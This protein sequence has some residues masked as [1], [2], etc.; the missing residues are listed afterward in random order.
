[1]KTD[2]I[3][4]LVIGVWGLIILLGGGLLLSGAFQSLTTTA[5]PQALLAAPDA[6]PSP[7]LLQA[8]TDSPH[9]TAPAP[10]PNLTSDSLPE[11]TARPTVTP[12]PVFT[13]QSAA[14]LA[15]PGQVNPLTGQVISD[16]ALLNRRPV[17]VKMVNYPRSMRP[18][19]SGLSLADVVWE[20]Y[21]EDGLSRYV[22][23]YYANA[24]NRAGP[25]RS[26]RF[27]DEHLMRMYNAYLVF[28]NADDRVE[29]YFISTDL[30]PYLVVPRADNCPPLCR[31]TSIPGF[32]NVFADVAGLHTWLVK[33]DKD[34]SRPPVRTGYF[35]NTLLPWMGQHAAA[36]TIRFS[37][38][39]YAKWEYDPE[40]SRW[41][42][43][44]DTADALGSAPEKFAP[45]F[46]DLTD[47]QV[48]A[49]NVVVLFVPHFPYNKDDQ[50]YDIQL[51]GSGPATLFRDGRAYAVKWVRDQVNQP[52]A[53]TDP[54]GNLM[55]LKPGN[56][57]YEVLTDLTETTQNGA[58]Y[59]YRFV[60][61]P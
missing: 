21:I 45:L 17:A 40:T 13:P 48:A 19:Q 38:Y 56:T 2:H 1:M 6:P 36:I 41:L 16:P 54:A 10:S 7:R 37:G 51:V 32:N 33:T 23:V 39:A 4:W 8:L 25:V 52:I 58:D 53:I 11:P 49:D 15:A 60:L 9:A 59:R 5:S 35:S 18:N 28:A 30:L 22:A 31:D 57:F 12:L 47:L 20:H 14:S 29:D 24:P 27:F 55:P 3:K 42:R 44:Q 26:G 50:V 43:W 34:D 61:P 46:D